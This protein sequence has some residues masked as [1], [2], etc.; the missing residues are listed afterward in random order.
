MTVIRQN[1]KAMNVRWVFKIKLNPD[2]SV[3]KH[4][5][6]L[7]ARGFLQKSGVDY[8]EVF[9]LVARHEII[10]LVI[11]IVVNRNW[12]CWKC[13][14]VSICFTVPTG[15][16]A[17]LPSFCILTYVWSKGFKWFFIGKIIVRMITSNNGK[18]FGKFNV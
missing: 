4:K 8:F 3:I 11:F 2:D 13:F 5:E 18:I 6:R 10:R 12:P 17:I 9:S 14:S 16:G 15:I 7:V 1:K